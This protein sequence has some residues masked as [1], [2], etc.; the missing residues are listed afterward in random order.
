MCVC[1]LS[2]LCAEALN[3]FIHLTSE[4]H[5]EAWNSLLMLLLTKTLQ[6]PKDKVRTNTHTHT[7]EL[8]ALWVLESKLVI[9][10]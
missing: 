4:S 3:Y 9:I 2:R 10:S 7:E 5:R 6:L 1:V 8:L